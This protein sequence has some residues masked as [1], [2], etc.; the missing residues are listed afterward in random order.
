ME[1]PETV[2]SNRVARKIRILA[3]GALATTAL[4]LPALS[5][6]T[7]AGHDAGRSVRVSPASHRLAA[8]TPKPDSLRLT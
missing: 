4:C 6:V 1:S 5:A 7:I 2:S 8:S 3:I